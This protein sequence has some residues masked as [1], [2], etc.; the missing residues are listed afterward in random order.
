MLKNI[1]EFFGW[2]QAFCCGACYA[3]RPP[4]GGVLAA[5]FSQGPASRDITNWSAAEERAIL[6]SAMNSPRFCR[7]HQPLQPA[8]GRPARFSVVDPRSPS[9]HHAPVEAVAPDSSPKALAALLEG[10]RFV[11]L[12][13][14]AEHR[15]PRPRASGA[16]WR[17]GGDH[18]AERGFCV[19]NCGNQVLVSRCRLCTSSLRSHRTEA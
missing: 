17:G 8:I 1:H 4:S 9:G 6:T 10:R 13:G 16:R 7:H 3:D 11:V 15:P 2:M 18:N 5:V 19:I 14:A 12:S